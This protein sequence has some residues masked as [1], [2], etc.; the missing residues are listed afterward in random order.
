MAERQALGRGLSALIREPQRQAGEVRSLPVADIRPNASQPRRRFDEGAIAELA[1]SIREKGILQPI[2]VRRDDLG[3]EIVIGERRW[4]AARAAG[5][6]S[7]PAI[8]RE[9]SD[10]ESLELALVENIQREDLNPIELATAYRGLLE[11]GGLTQEEL[12]KRLGKDRATVA[13]TLRL[14]ALPPDIQQN[15]IEGSL[16]MGHA[17][18]LLSAGNAARQ[19]AIRDRILREGLSVREVERLAQGERPASPAGRPASHKLEPALA[20]LQTQLQGHFQTPVVLRRRGSR[21]TIEITFYGDNDLDR[22]VRLL[23]D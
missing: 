6:A 9:T 3:Y 20:H 21:G 14:L 10:R 8:V 23:L 11:L 19:R 2:V 1:A 22:I 4:R 7:I 15:V 18:A 17:R 5:I 16:S 13:N 12:A